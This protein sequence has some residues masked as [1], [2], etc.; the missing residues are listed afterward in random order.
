MK[1]STI[2]L[3]FLIAAVVITG[4]IWWKTQHKQPVI[5]NG[6]PPF[7]PVPL[8]QQQSAK[9]FLK[10]MGFGEF[11]LDSISAQDAEIARIY[12]SEYLKKGIKM[13]STDALYNDVTRIASYS[14]IFNKP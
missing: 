14:G 6:M 9:D 2:I 8:P 11:V 13:L 3:I 10:S 4:V 12:I 7:N 5:I 1:T